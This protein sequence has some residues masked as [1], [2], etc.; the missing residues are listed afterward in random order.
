MSEK[1]LAIIIRYWNICLDRWSRNLLKGVYNTD[2]IYWLGKSKV[3]TEIFVH[4]S[5]LNRR[6]KK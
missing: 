4:Y 1:E 5:K 6:N 2:R 3:L